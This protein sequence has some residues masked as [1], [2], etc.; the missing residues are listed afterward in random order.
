MITTDC[1]NN[2]SQATLTPIAYQIK[3]TLK[4]G[5][6]CFTDWFF[7]NKENDTDTFAFYYKPTWGI[8]GFKAKGNGE[9]EIESRH[10]STTTDSL[11]E[12]IEGKIFNRLT[13]PQHWADEGIAQPNMASKVKAFEICRHLFQKHS[14]IPDRYAATKEEGIFL[15]FD[16]KNGEKT[17]IIEV[18]NDLEAGLLINDN[19]KRKILLSEEIKALEF[20]KAVKILN[21]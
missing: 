11:L 19:D 20:S 5:Q 15:A 14:L 13:F 9:S 10:I 21:G 16:T 18:Y 2:I 1:P 6:D 7:A 12:K 3:Q 8:F 17:L 4:N